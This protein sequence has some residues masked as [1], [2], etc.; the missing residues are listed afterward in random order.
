LARATQRGGRVAGRYVYGL[1]LISATDKDGNQRYYFADGLGSTVLTIAGQ[2]PVQAPTYRYDAFGALRSGTASREPFLF[3][4]EQYDARARGTNLNNGLYYLRARYYDQSI[5]RFLSQD[6]LPFGNRYPYV[7][8]DPVNRVDP[9]GLSPESTSNAGLVS[10]L[11]KT[12][13]PASCV[14]NLLYVGLGLFLLQTALVTAEPFFA[15]PL[16]VYASSL[17]LINYNSYITNCTSL[18]TIR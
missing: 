15:F 4:G 6:P 2:S 12:Y 8:N 16:A 1:D 11:F 7:G 10:D 9:R 14:N 13:Q 17:I 5:G 3:T 18:H